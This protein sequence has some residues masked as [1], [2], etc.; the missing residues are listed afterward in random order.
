MRVVLFFQPLLWCLS[1]RMEEAAEEVC[2]DHVVHWGAD[3]SV[4]ADGLVRLAEQR[5]LPLST[6]VPLVRFRSLLG[7]RVQRILDRSHRLS[8]RAGMKAL[9][10]IAAAGLAVT[11]VVALVAPS[12]RSVAAP[13]PS[14]AKKSDAGAEK[15]SADTAKAAETPNVAKR[16]SGT[17]LLPS[18]KPAAG[19]H[20]VLIGQ[21]RQATR[22]C[23]FDS[24]RVRLLAHAQCNA[25]GRFELAAA[26]LSSQRYLWVQLLARSA[27][28]GLAWR[29]VNADEPRASASI[30]LP[31]AAA[32]RG[33]L[34]TL[35][36]RPAGGVRVT[37]LSVTRSGARGS[38]LDDGVYVDDMAPAEVWPTGVISDPDGWFTV[39][40]IAGD[41]ELGLYIHQEPFAAERLTF[42]RTPTDTSRH[43]FAL[44][45]AQ[46]VKGVI[47]AADT[48]KP[49]ENAAI[50]VNQNWEE[51]ANRGMMA[52]E[53]K[54]DAEGRFRLNP[55]A[56][57][58]YTV[59]A[60]GAKGTPYLATQL[61]IKWSETEREHE[62]RLELPRGV[63]VHGTALEE[64]G[65]RPV[66]NA[67]V[68]YS[69]N[70]KNPH[71]KNIPLEGIYQP[72]ELSDEQG[73]F[74][75]AVPAGK[76]HLTV[77]SSTGEH[78]LKELDERQIGEGRPGGA[79]W[80]V[81]ADAAIDLTDDAREHTVDFKLQ[82]GVTVKGELVR[83]DGR[84]PERVIMIHRGTTGNFDDEFRDD[85]TT[86]G[87]NRFE[88]RGVPPDGEFPAFFLDPDAKQGK[89]LPIRSSDAGKPLRVTLEPC[90]SLS[91]RFLDP[92]GKP[93]AGHIPSLMIVFTPGKPSNDLL[94]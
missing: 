75:I 33:R 93:V 16:I 11:L 26:D 14:E 80:Y 30:K 54:T 62:L 94:K 18:G 70:W 23:D 1:R 5:S 82:R 63:L 2:D 3:R 35:E 31:E 90:G 44:S 61:E 73:H 52:V 46:I 6:V 47:V 59:T 68:R 79:R 57:K 88:I 15:K 78:V 77:K 65:G 8:L 21:L 40:G 24:P 19:A 22:F 12:G 91:L 45:P 41:V 49:L 87:G 89:R 48:G 67:T 10:A 42:E 66:A 25:M 36:G 92:D 81:N 32:T 37:V 17:V 28:S 83:T 27:D 51:D 43:V 20:V 50:R 29:E 39:P 38:G 55:Y 58:A 72:T 4:Y 71:A 86:L 85:P 7:R 56:A 84:T 53:G 74:T 34:L 9:C 60:I 64:P 69:A 76:G 13:V